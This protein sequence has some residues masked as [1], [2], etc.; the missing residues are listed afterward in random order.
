M[1]SFTD[2]VK[3]GWNRGR[4]TGRDYSRSDSRTLRRVRAL[5]FFAAVLVAAWAGRYHG[6]PAGFALG[7]LVLT[8]PP[9]FLG[10]FNALKEWRG[11][12]REAEDPW[13]SI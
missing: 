5:S 2:S 7:V 13:S 11:E 10:A 8:A 4:K 1:T 9:G 6:F 3:A 12:R